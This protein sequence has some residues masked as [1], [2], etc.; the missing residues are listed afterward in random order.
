LAFI[1]VFLIVL[2]GGVSV[3]QMNKI[4]TELVDIAE[5]D[6]PISNKLSDISQHQLEQAILF[7]RGLSYA[8]ATKYGENRSQEL[9]A[10]LKKFRGLAESV[11]EEFKHLEEMLEHAIKEAQSAEAEAQFETLLDTIVK[12]DNNHK[13]YDTQALVLLEK[14]TAGTASQAL[15]SAPGIIALEDK[16]DHEL[17]AALTQIQQF[18]LEASQRAEHDEIAALKIIASL[19]IAAL[20]MATIVPILMSKSIVGPVVNMR[21]RLRE[22]AE[23]DGDLSVRLP[24]TGKDETSDAADAFNKLL[25][26]LGRMVASIRN[27]SS[28]LAERSEN[29]I[30]VMEAT[31]DQ[32]N[33]QK[34]ETQL[35]ATSVEEMAGSVSEIAESTVHAANLGSNVLDKVQIGSEL[36]V[37]NQSV[38]QQL[39]HNVENAATKLTSLAEET[40]RIGEVLGDI[41]G[42]AEQTNLLALNAA[43]EAARA[44]E[45]GR[46]FA[47]VADEVRSL[48]QRTQQSTENIQELLQN[49][50]GGTSGAVEVMQLSQENAALCITQ[51]QKTAA[52]LSEASSAV[53]SMSAMNTQIAAAAEEQSAVVR[54]I[55]MNLS[56]ISEYANN[57]SDSADKT[58]DIS[59]EISLGLKQLDLL[60]SELRT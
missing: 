17:V 11:E 25:E 8:V 47:V 54:D 51:A 37:K 28:G 19:F 50:Q 41:R 49:L 6:I 43:I 31:R 10:A 3:I 59:M 34:S 18:T 42:I 35:V 20:I 23:G 22:L 48:S 32:V 1:N 4:G 38:I 40:N 58:A 13:T 56:S 15:V 45:S 60:V 16:I 26:K 24:V 44:G 39:S 21:D 12:I 30:V 33:Q 9:E 57:T 14:V 46:G 53:E 36:A 55:H 27:T 29:T 52:E 5:Q 2:I 7:E